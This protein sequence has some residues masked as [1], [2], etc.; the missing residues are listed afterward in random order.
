MLQFGYIVRVWDEPD[1]ENKITVHG[2]TI[3]ETK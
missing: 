3:F 2:N 1:I